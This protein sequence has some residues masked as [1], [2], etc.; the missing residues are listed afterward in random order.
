MSNYTPTTIFASLNGTPILGNPFDIEFGNISTAIASKYDGNSTSGNLTL[1]NITAT[2]VLTC[3]SLVP[4]GSVA[5]TNGM[6]LPSANKIGFSTNGLQR[7]TIASNGQVTINAPPVSVSSLF[8]SGYAGANNTAMIAL[9]GGISVIGLTY[10]GQP[11]ITVTGSSGGN[12]SG[13]GVVQ[14]TASLGLTSQ[15]YLTFIA[16]A[17]T[18]PIPFNFDTA[19][20][21]STGTTAAVLTSNKPSGSGTSV[22]GWL[23][24][25]VAGSTYYMPVW[26]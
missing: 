12:P 2:G 7:L 6:Y 19:S 26:N 18:T 21:F 15:R 17:N 8:V 25:D 5:P 24:V 22:A 13:G 10:N 16:N 20:F 4:I 23:T 11:A 9:N 1:T 14:I 3:A